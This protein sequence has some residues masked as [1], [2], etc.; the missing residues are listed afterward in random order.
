[1][2]ERGPGA[3]TLVWARIAG[4]SYVAIIAIGAIVEGA[5]TPALVVDGDPAA[6]FA[7]IEAHPA[8]FRVSAFAVLVLYALVLL[9]S[10]ALYEILRR[11]DRGVA[12]LALVFRSAEGILGLATVL[13]GLVVMQLTAGSTP[14]LGSAHGDALVW[15]FL[16]ARAASMD[17]VLLL[18]GVGGTSYCY[19]FL[20]S[21]SIPRWLAAWGVVTY[22]SMLVLATVSFL[23]PDHPTWLDA[24]FYGAGA[25]FEVLIGLWLMIR[26]VDVGSPK[27]AEVAQAA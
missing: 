17:V 9:L 12:L 5:A 11:V 26:G 7:N 22:L 21:R 8:V 20:K 13:L 1:M 6:T 25:L 18:I 14:A 24:V 19:L 16:Q 2:A 10:V 3:R 15:S 27:G 4:L 23:F